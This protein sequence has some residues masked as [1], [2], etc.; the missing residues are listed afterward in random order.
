MDVVSPEK[1]SVDQITDQ[2]L[3][4][5]C[6]K[7]DPRL[8]KNV[9]KTC[10]AKRVLLCAIDQPLY[11]DVVNVSLF[12]KGRLRVTV[13]TG[14]SAPAVARKIREGLEASLKDVPLDKYLDDL[15]ALHEKLEHEIPNPPDR[16]PHLLKAAEGFEFKA[17]VKFPPDWRP[18]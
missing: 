18:R 17:S 2:F 6:P 3:V 9:A 14:G 8:T 15:A 11:C 13:G 16:I 10:R 1:F 7:T 5:F 12:D 4:V